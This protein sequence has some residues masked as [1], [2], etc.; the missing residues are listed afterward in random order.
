MSF[1]REYEG[2]REKKTIKV[3]DKVSVFRYVLSDPEYTISTVAQ[4][5]DV[6]QQGDQSVWGPRTILVSDGD[7]IRYSS[8]KYEPGLFW[9]WPELLAGS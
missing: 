2:I 8:K 3:R 4:S 6:E 1:V 5:K 9:T 7:G